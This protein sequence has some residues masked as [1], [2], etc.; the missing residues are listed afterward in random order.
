MLKR[1]ILNHSRAKITQYP[2]SKLCWMWCYTKAWHVMWFHFM[3]YH[4]KLMRALLG[5]CFYEHLYCTDSDIV[6]SVFLF[7]W[8]IYSLYILLNLY[9]AVCLLNSLNVITKSHVMWCRLQNYDAT[10]RLAQDIAENIHERSRLQRTGGNPAKV[11]QWGQLC[12]RRTLS[13]P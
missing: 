7:F 5:P 4:F 10:C 13:A 9:V 8:Q 2:W 11:R 3:W 12:T 1:L 6:C